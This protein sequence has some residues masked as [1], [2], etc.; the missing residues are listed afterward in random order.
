M[1]RNDWI[2]ATKGMAIFLV[3]LGH[4]TGGVSGAGIA[5]SDL[6]NSVIDGIY[7]FH[8]PLF[9]ALSGWF[10]MRL[11]VKNGLLNFSLRRVE[12]ILYPM[13]LWTYIFFAFKLVAG[14]YSNSPVSLQDI[15]LIPVPGVLHFWFLWDL[16][17]LSFLFFP[18]RYIAGHIAGRDAMLILLLLLAFGLR[19]IPLTEDV[20]YWIGSALTNA[21]FFMLGIVL[22]QRRFAPQGSA[23][24][25]GAFATFVLVQAIWP[26]LEPPVSR[27]IASFVLVFCVLIVFSAGSHRLPAMLR[28]LLCWLGMASMTIY[29]AHTI[30]SAA[31][32]EVLFK[33]GIADPVLQI[34]FGTLIG[35]G[36]PLVLLA[37]ARRLGLARALGLEL[38]QAQATV[39]AQ[40]SPGTAH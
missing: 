22:G 23:L 15:P 35:L 4:A 27:A 17:I 21:P 5:L 36:G 26:L 28:S 32:R 12:R 6:W 10:Y 14:Q 33:I 31:L 13:I 8:M 25:T 38:T 24:A 2:D 3:V 16:F 11:V 40:P 30:F 18:L 1:V 9:F 29:V 37:V 39:K 19:F 7:A 34:I 20:N